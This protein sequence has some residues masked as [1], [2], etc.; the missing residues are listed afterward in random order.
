MAG[1]NNIKMKPKLIGAFLFAGLLPLVIIALISTNKSGTALEEALF[2]QLKAVQAIKANQVKTFFDERISDAKVFSGM[3]FISKAVAELDELSKEAKSAGFSGKKLLE[4]PA[5]KSAF[6]KYYGVV[7]KFA[8]TY[9][10]Y[11]V[12]LFSPN[13]GRVLLTAALEDD[14]GTELKSE[15]HNLAQVWKKMKNTKRSVLSEM[16]P[17]APSDGAPA[18]FIVTPSFLDG[19]YVGAIGLQISN[20]SINKI[21]QERSGM[22]ETGETY[23]VGPDKKMRSDSYLDTKNH[24]V[25]AS[26]KGS[27][28]KNGVD[29]KAVDEAIAGNSGAEIIT[30]YN[31]NPVLSVYSP[32]DL[33]GG[34]RWAA[35]AEIDLAEVEKPVDNLRSSIL[36]LGLLIAVLVAGFAF[37]IA[38]SLAKPIKNIAEVAKKIAEGDLEQELNIYQEDEI[39][40]LANS[41]RDMNLALK[42]KAEVAGQIASGNLDIEVKALSKADVLGHAMVRMRQNLEQSK[43]EVTTAL[44][45]AQQKVAYLDNL[46][47]PVHVIDKNMVVQYMNP[48]AAKVCGQS[49][50]TC[51]GKKCYDLLTNPHCNTANCA[52]LKAMKQDKVI[53]SE[54]VITKNGQSIPIQY[55]GAPVKDADGNI[56]GAMEQAVDITEVKNVVNEVNHIADLLNEGRLDK[57]A[58]VEGAKGDYKKLVDG[59]NMAIDNIIEPVEEAQNCLAEMAL[60]DLTVQMKGEYKGDHAKMKDALNNTLYALNDLLGQVSVAAEQVASGAVQVSDSSQSISQGSTEAASSLEETSAS[61]AEISQ[62]SRKN[63]E[64]S[65]AANDLAVSSKTSAETGN[66]RMDKMLTAMGDINNSS[67]EISKIIKVIDEIAFQTNLLALNAAVEAARAGVHGKGFAVVAEEVRNLAQRSAKAAKETTELIEGSV[68]KVQTGTKIANQT[69]EALTGIIDGITKVS[70]LVEEIA[71][72]SNEQVAAIDQTS[73]ALGQIDEVTQS[74]SAAAEQGAAT[75]EELSAQSVQLKQILSKFKLRKQLGGGKVNTLL[76]ASGITHVAEADE[77]APVAR[78]KISQKK[79]PV[80]EPQIALDDDEFGAF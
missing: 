9:G 63:A 36:F 4:Y 10:Y 20:E 48:A 34:I 14:F 60:G 71:T 59:F 37:W 67:N 31:G 17:Y 75:A 33:Y 49:A 25:T 29:T 79:E 62:Q 77:D 6:N 39:G 58:E 78:K 53:T 3:P 51:V 18:M 72:A 42:E 55:T 46:T 66:E 30:D 11:D 65:A 35:I 68:N 80:E 26:F 73:S 21:M 54:T 15:N 41:F 22:G 16:K 23:L 38:L 13:S 64:N 40:Q 69:A 57:R 74:Q 7:K 52:T 8:E 1:I 28:E 44:N 45:D 27:V 19:S 70:S 32:I 50:E 61:I 76:K 43:K 5:Y 56:I 12:F 24:S 47:F 2:N